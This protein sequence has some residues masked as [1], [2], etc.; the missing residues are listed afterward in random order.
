MG[1][2]MQVYINPDFVEPLYKSWS[3]SM[4]IVEDKRQRDSSW[5]KQ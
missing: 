2:V 1:H 4:H 5:Q 3:R